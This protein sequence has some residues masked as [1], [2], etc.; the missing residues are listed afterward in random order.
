MISRD[1]GPRRCVDFPLPEHMDMAWS[2]YS[3]RSSDE[4]SL[5]LTRVFSLLTFAD[6][7]AIG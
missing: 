4:Q 7:V 6:D 1:I 5:V 3:T 2:A